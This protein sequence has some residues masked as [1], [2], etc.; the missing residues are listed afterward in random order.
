MEKDFLSEVLI[1]DEIDQK[2]VSILKADGKL[3]TKEIA[4][5]IGLT[6]TPTYER[7]RRL[8]KRGVIKSYAAIIDKKKQGLTLNVLCNVQLK[9]HAA[10]YLSEF[11]AAIIQLTEI[12][13]CFHI[14]GNFDYLLKI[15]VK[16]MDAYSIFVK[17]KL[18]VIPHIATVQSSFI[19]RTLK[20]EY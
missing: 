6:N 13:D 17:E 9:S 1:L 11:E 2:I 12:T 19:M 18:A 16:D 7:I 8:E 14:A 20:E 10:E 4:N 3:G 5:Q 15:T